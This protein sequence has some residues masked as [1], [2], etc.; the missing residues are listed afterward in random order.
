MC[1]PTEGRAR[2]TPRSDKAFERGGSLLIRRITLLT[3][4]TAVAAIMLAAPLGASGGFPERISL[5]DRFR[6]EGI[7][8]G[9]QG[10]FYV[11]SIPTGAISTAAISGPVRGRPSFPA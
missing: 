3:V 5:P 8:I 6:P 2:M 1:H 7:A 4:W 11:G 9:P 10:T